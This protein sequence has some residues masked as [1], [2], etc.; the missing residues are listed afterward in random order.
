MA[1]YFNKSGLPDPT[2]YEA[3]S[4]IERESKGHKKLPYLPRIYIST[5]FSTHP[6]LVRD[7]CLFAHK[8]GYAPFSPLLMYRQL[9]DEET[10]KVMG[11]IFLD[12]CIQVWVFGEK[13]KF[14]E[15]EIKRAKAQGKPVRFF[16][17]NCK[18][19]PGD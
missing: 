15:R 11:Q 8:E 4:N 17:F 1:N 9:F 2:A 19:V 14:T 10:A 18:E 12:C 16:D 6:N 5:A 7:Y 13:D 3:L